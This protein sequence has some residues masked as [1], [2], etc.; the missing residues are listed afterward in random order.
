MSLAQQLRDFAIDAVFRCNPNVADVLYELAAILETGMPVQESPVAP[1]VLVQLDDLRRVVDAVRVLCAPR[2]D[3]AGA[4]GRL[5]D[6]VVEAT[7]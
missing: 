7:R 3:L 6:A 2:P 1:V 5:S 4:A